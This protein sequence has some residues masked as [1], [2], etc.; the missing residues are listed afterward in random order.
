MVVGVVF[1]V[2]IGI[3]LAML[4]LSGG[5]SGNSPE[6]ALNGF[7]AGV[8]SGDAREAFDHTILALMPGY[9]D[10]I[11]YLGGILLMGDPHIEINSVTEI[12]NETMTSDELEEAEDIIDEM[13]M[14]LDIDVE[15][16]AFV[17]YNMTM[18]YEGIGG[19]SEALEGQM[20]C[21]KVDGTWYLAMLTFFDEF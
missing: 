10:Q 21:V 17:E 11:D 6:G 8:N 20:L 18:E 9:E 7:A 2:L 12:D 15:D 5:G 3:V 13:L 14:Y 4:L 1:I 19:G 16:M